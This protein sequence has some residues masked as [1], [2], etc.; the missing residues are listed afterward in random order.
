MATLKLPKPFV[1]PDVTATVQVAFENT[2]ITLAA[3]AVPSSVTACL[4][5]RSAGVV[6]EITGRAGAVESST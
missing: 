3:S 1:V 5:E 2:E 6:P 4:L